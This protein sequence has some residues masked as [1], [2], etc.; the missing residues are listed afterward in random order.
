MAHVQH[1][2]VH[3]EKKPTSKNSFLCKSPPFMCK[4]ESCTASFSSEILLEQ[5]SEFHE[6][7]KPSNKKP[8]EQ[9]QGKGKFLL[10]SHNS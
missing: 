1:S 2:E 4:E 5:H 9:L 6:R 8:V 7:K 10:I 3:E